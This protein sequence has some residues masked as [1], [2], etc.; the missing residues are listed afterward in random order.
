MTSTAR[1]W[2]EYLL[3]DDAIL[4][5]DGLCGLTVC[6]SADEEARLAELCDHAVT[7]IGGLRCDAAMM[8]RAGP[9]LRAIIRLGIGYDRVDVRAATE[10]G[11]IVINT[12]DGP[13]ESTAEHAIALLLGLTK[14]VGFTSH[15]LHQGQSFAMRNSLVPGLETVGA[16]LGLVGLGR[17]GR[18]VAEI[19]RVLGMRVLAIDPAIDAATAAALGVELTPDLPL[20]L[21]SSDVVSLHAPAIPATYRLINAA[22]LALMKPGAY[23]VNVARGELVDEAALLEA[24]QHGHLAGAALDVFDPEPPHPDNPLLK[25]PNVIVTPHIAS[26]TLASQRRMH[27]MAAEQAAMLLRGERPTTMVNPEVWERRRYG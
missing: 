4:L 15:Q 23:L 6:G 10:R 14:L 8:D 19:A 17:I 16:T 9:G 20:L 24:L 21:S 25:L 5:L 1:A 26:Y 18:R 3:H 7:F 11:I 27:M 13:T 2:S 22:T 12:P